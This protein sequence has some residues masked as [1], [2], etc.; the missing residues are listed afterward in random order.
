[1]SW[2]TDTM[3]SAQGTKFSFDTVFLENGEIVRV[4]KR[5]RAKTSFTVAEAEALKAEAFANGQ[6]DATARSQAALAQSLSGIA[7]AISTLCAELAAMTA[8]R[9]QESASLALA[10]AR[11][12]AGLALQHFPAADL[13]AAVAQ[14]L[15]DLHNEP[16]LVIRVHHT[17]ATELQN[18][19]DTLSMEAGFNGRVVITSDI[20]I[21][22]PDIRIE[23]S[24]GGMERSVDD[25]FARMDAA[26]S[27][28]IAAD[29]NAT[30]AEQTS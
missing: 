10:A 2:C 5:E 4:Q 18:V 21:K 12:A 9:R 30:G 8:Q 15:H 3:T 29:A 20:D 7:A 13:E 6:R 25:I 27:R 16:R 19:I 28:W 17:T 26:L 23:W 22:A 14:A 11:R 24:E 1:M